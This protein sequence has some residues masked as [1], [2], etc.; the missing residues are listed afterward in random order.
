MEM[1]NNKILMIDSLIGNDYSIFLCNELV[2][3]GID[4]S[5]LLTEDRVINV[6]TNFNILRIM[7]SKDSKKSKIKK[8]IAF[9]V[10][11]IKIIKLIFKNNYKI[12]HYQFFRYKSIETF[13][14]VL[15]KLFPV[16]LFH[17][18]HDVILVNEKKINM[19]YNKVIYKFSD[20]I[21]VHSEKN[22]QQLS[23][24]YK[25]CNKKIFVTPHGSFDY[26]RGSTTIDSNF[27]KT[28]F[29]VTKN[30]L[31]LLFF[32]FIKE[33]KG[34][35][36]LL[37]AMHNIKNLNLALIIAGRFESIEIKNNIM[38]QIKNLPPNITII[39]DFDFI[40]EEKIPIYFTIADIVVLPY[41]RISH[42]GVL[43]LAYSFSK[44]VL[45]TNVGDF[46]ESVE[47]FK[48]GL[49]VEPNVDSIQTA[50]ERIVS[51]D[52]DLRSMGLYANKLNSSKY[53]WTASAIKLKSA[54]EVILNRSLC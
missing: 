15:L 7:P 39:K 51:D 10:Y 18:A 26:Y 6:K 43:H 41:K 44:P 4:V 49:L 30:Q 16:K 11:M 52:L 22:K 9:P 19:F 3:Q 8:I 29:A 35:D 50:I 38:K 12:V 23:D 20:A 1:N 13:F 37:E 53:S 45:A 27:Y 32:G 48:S 46:D 24:L 31:V 17:T 5:L 21:I 28:K 25:I 36:L 14:Y 33:Y 2:K 34:L 47:N 54:Y 40:D 42:S